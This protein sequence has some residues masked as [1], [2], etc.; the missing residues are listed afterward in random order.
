MEGH[1]VLAVLTDKGIIIADSNMPF[2]QVLKSLDEI[3]QPPFNYKEVNIMSDE[4][5]TKWV[6]IYKVQ[7]PWYVTVEKTI[8]K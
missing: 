6:P 5:P 8:K 4:S 1:L 3:S 7:R 2:L